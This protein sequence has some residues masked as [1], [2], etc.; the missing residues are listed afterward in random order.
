MCLVGK[1]WREGRREVMS[2]YSAKSKQVLP[3]HLITM[4]Y[5][6][7]SVQSVPLGQ[8]NRHL[9]AVPVFQPRFVPEPSEWLAEER[10][11]R[12][13]GRVKADHILTIETK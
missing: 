11:K 7:C 2:P 8:W 3:S 6:L 1:G 13:E 10:R 9:L 12:R 5:I 4:Q